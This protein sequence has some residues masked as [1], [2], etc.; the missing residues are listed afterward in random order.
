VIGHAYGTDSRVWE[1]ADSNLWLVP[2][3]APS[4]IFAFQPIPIAFLGMGAAWRRLSIRTDS[5][6]RPLLPSKH[7]VKSHPTNDI[8]N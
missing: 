6:V 1:T 7:H 2:L 5:D 3:R 4:N 8:L